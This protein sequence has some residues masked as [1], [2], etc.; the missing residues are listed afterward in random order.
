MLCNSETQRF[1]FNYVGG[2]LCKHVNKSR[3]PVSFRGVDNV[4]AKN[5]SNIRITTVRNPS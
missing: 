1:F 5:L 3:S 2:E 4:H